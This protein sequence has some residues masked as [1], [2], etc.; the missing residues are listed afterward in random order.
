MADANHKAAQGIAA[1]IQKFPV[2]GKPVAS[3][4]TDVVS[5]PTRAESVERPE[6]PE[7]PLAAEDLAKPLE[8]KPIRCLKTVTAGTILSAEVRPP[9]WVWDGWIP[10]GKVGMLAAVSD[11]GKTAF[12]LQLAVGIAS[13]RPVLGIPTTPKPCGVL[14]YSLEDDP[15]DFQPRMRWVLEGMES[16]GTLSPLD[17]ENVSRNLWFASPT[18]EVPDLRFERTAREFRGHLADMRK[19]GIEP[20][21]VIVETLS[22]VTEGDESQAHTTRALW[23]SARNIAYHEDVTVLITHHYRKEAGGGKA[24]RSSVV[25]RIEPD[26]VRGSSANEGAARFVVQMGL[27]TMDEAEAAGLDGHKALNKGYAILRASKLK[28]HKP[29]MLFLE[30]IDKD[31][32]GQHTWARHPKGDV[33]IANLLKSTSK[34]K[35]LNQEDKVLVELFRQGTDPDREKLKELFKGANDPDKALTNALSGLRRKNEVQARKLLLTIPGRERAISLSEEWEETADSMGA[36]WVLDSVPSLPQ[37]FPQ[38]IEEKLASSKTLSSLVP[39]EAE[40]KREFFPELL[41]LVPGDDFDQSRE[42]PPG[43]GETEETEGKPQT[44]DKIPSFHSGPLGPWNGRKESKNEKIK[45]SGR[46]NHL[47]LILQDD[48]EN[49]GFPLGR[50]ETEEVEQ[51]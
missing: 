44:E 6:T 1:T 15:E 20:A 2:V 41:P 43:R 45:P 33:I 49:I 36:A 28:A 31:E 4:N 19:K 22:A 29:D 34:L 40:E 23:A 35:E 9:R 12:I 8:E 47:G 37:E 16:A 18:Y 21:L 50:G 42:L 51:M 14:F 24:N 13:G 10:R 3:H 30:R 32:V 7:R 38:E 26:K 27:P 46:K 11:H 17:R 5:G 48:L 25:E 39:L